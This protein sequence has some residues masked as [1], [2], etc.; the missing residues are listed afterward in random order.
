MCRSDK[1]FNI[2]LD[3]WSSLTIN[4]IDH[5]KLVNVKATDRLVHK[6]AHIWMKT[7]THQHRDRWGLALLIFIIIVFFI[8]SNQ[9]GLKFFRIFIMLAVR[10][11]SNN[12]FAFLINTVKAYIFLP[13]ICAVNIWKLIICV[14]SHTNK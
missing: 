3:K 6:Q 14:Y 5:V 2:A 13:N 8:N 1:C 11:W 9:K 12:C 7:S 10:P 4:C